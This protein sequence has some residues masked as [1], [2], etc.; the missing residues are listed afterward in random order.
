MVRG[1]EHL[2]YEL[3]LKELGLFSP[4]KTS[5]P[6]TTYEVTE[7]MKPG[8]LLRCTEARLIN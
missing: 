2:C 6:S 8:C 5:Q 1:V 4:E 3:I 7:N